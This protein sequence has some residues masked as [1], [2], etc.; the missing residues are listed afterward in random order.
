MVGNNSIQLFLTRNDQEAMPERVREHLLPEGYFLFGARNPS[1][2]H[3]FEWGKA[4]GRRAK[5]PQAIVPHGFSQRSEVR[6]A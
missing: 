1:C 6:E 4:E 2:Y 5:D 3:L